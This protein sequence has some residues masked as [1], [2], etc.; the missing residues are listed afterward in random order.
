MPERKLRESSRQ[1]F[2][3]IASYAREVKSALQKAVGY[4]GDGNIH[5]ENA[6]FPRIFS[7]KVEIWKGDIYAGGV[8]IDPL[9]GLLKIDKGGDFGPMEWDGPRTEN[10]F[11]S[12]DLDSIKDSISR[13]CL[14]AGIG[15]YDAARTSNKET[16]NNDVARSK[17][18]DLIESTCKTR[19][20][21]GKKIK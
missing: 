16:A 7:D 19:Q 17:D 3:E 21:V 15:I 5:F 6:Y 8:G 4:F 1:C 18:H 9:S 2:I 11:N 13:F 20:D 12:V 14:D 10:I